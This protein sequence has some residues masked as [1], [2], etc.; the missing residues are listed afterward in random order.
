MSSNLLSPN[1]LSLCSSMVEHDTVNIRVRCSIH[2]KGAR[3]ISIMV[4]YVTFN[5]HY[6]GSNPIYPIK[7]LSFNGRI[8]V[9]Q[10][11]YVSSIL[12]NRNY[13]N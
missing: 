2:L 6:M 12:T 1:S 13:E 10:T 5:H 8:T 11:E 7:R 9:F 3:D 4:M